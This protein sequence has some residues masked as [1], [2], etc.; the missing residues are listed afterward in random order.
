MQ[1]KAETV[2]AY[3]AEA[4]P[5]R[6]PHLTRVRDAARRVLTAHTEAM[7]YGMPTY[8]RGGAPEFAFANQKQYLAL[9]V[10][11]TGVHAKNAEALA[12]I[13]CGKGCIRFRKPEQL[14]EAL[15]ERLLT[16]TRDLDG[17]VC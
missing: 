12:G 17:P 9:Y 6:A 14:D 15:L 16:D 7:A 10:M 11:K 1:S 8:S 2:D 5:E 13:D 4:S 3:I